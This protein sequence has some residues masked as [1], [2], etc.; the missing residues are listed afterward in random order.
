MF[1]SPASP[2]QDDHYE[3]TIS[4]EDENDESPDQPSD[5][6]PNDEASDNTPNDAEA[7]PT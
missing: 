3:N 6:T 5:N 2:H 1:D 7:T 4:M